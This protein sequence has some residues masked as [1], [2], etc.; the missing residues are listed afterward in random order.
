VSK[1]R[2][3]WVRITLLAAVILTGGLTARF[4]LQATPHD[5]AR[6]AYE[7]A[8]T[9]LKQNDLR[10][11]KV[12]LMNAVTADPKWPDALIAQAQVSLDLFDPLTAQSALE[13][14]VAAGVPKSKVAHLLGQAL[15]MQGDLDQAAAVLTDPAI[16][17]ANRAYAN[18]IMGRVMMD[19][20]DLAA[21]QA[22]LA[23]AARLAP[24]NATVWTDM[25]RLRFVTADQKGAIEAVDYALKLDPN[26]V[27][28][29]EFR[30][31]LIRSQFGL[32]AA[33][34]WFERGLQINSTDVPLLEEY[35][36][37]LGEAGRNTDMLKIARKIIL[38]DSGNA[39]A[40]YIQAVIAA[41]AGNY[42]L[43]KRILPRAGSKFNE[44]PAPMLVNA[45]CEYELG[46]F[47]RSIDQLQRLL[48]LQPRNLTVRT[49]LA[50][51][52]YRA[53]DPLDALD[54]IRPIAR[55]KDAD[56][57][58]LKLAG[59]AFEA[60][61]QR[62]R[63]GGALNDAMNSA[64]RVGLPFDGTESL[65]GAADAA[66]RSPDNARVIV[67]YIRVLM[68][69]GDLEAAFVEASR[70]QAGNQG[71]ADAHILVG[72]VEIL[73]G[74]LQQAVTAYQKAREIAFG[75]PVMLRLVDA[76]ARSG[77]NK[78]ANETLSAYLMYNPTSLIAQRLAGYRALDAGEWTDAIRLLEQVHAR[79][80]PNDYILLANLA[81]A[82]SGA[83]QHNVA[84][85]N[86][87]TAYRIAPASMMTTY[88]YGQVLLKSR[89][90]SKATVELLK[91]AAIL[92]PDNVQVRREL[93]QAT[94]N[95][96]QR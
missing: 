73:R 71:V 67:P 64:A 23:T 31:R 59:R 22:S 70:L 87:A 29:L 69:A 35:A 15:W 96:K 18:R 53:G 39:K 74:R 20:G 76:F 50:Q 63:A 21:A 51:A 16:P 3:S 1:R 83:G 61:G 27:R 95:Y 42:D 92:M 66:R 91:K 5:R 19:K 86:A 88:V 28:A 41:R 30:G 80:G 60:S 52:M 36:L 40:L 68:A 32:A 4:A 72:D 89:N 46:N 94:A 8:Q 25:A 57:Y 49:L 14:A 81:R 7:E 47:N 45:I 75:E 55:R 12:A 85:R 34:P 78:S 90:R 33:L 26:N 13:R 93:K 10:S 9:H 79:I 17:K 38:F 2:D 56:S 58:S 44:L 62:G 48:A 24:G 54:I 37:T 84:V 82:Y 6:E 77:D 43:A 65:A 11:A